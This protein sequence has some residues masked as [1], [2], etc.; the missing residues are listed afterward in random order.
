MLKQPRRH[1]GMCSSRHILQ[2]CASMVFSHFGFRSVAAA[3]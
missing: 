3:E 1:N 2:K